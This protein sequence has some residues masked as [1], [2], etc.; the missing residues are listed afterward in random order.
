MARDPMGDELAL[1][2]KV[3]I[4]ETRGRV[5]GQ[6]VSTAVGFVEEPAG[7]LL[8][9]A[10]DDRTQWARN[11]LADP[12]CRATRGTETL[13]YRAALLEGPE[14]NAAITSLI[15]AYGTPAERLGAGP[16]F[17]LVPD[18]NGIAAAGPPGP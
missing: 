10:T 18:P 12:R 5:S 6:R 9:S 16:T 17:R 4:L 1:W 8:I 13:M 2:G 11:L 15:L 7:T 14:R 3:L